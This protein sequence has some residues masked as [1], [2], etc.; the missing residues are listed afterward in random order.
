[1][2]QDLMMLKHRIII[3]LKESHFVTQK[4]RFPYGPD[5]KARDSK[6]SDLKTPPPA[7]SWLPQYSHYVQYTA[8]SAAVSRRVNTADT[9]MN[10][11]H[12]PLVL[13]AYLSESHHNVILSSPWS[14]K[15]PFPNRFSHENSLHCP[16]LPHMQ[17]THR[18]PLDVAVGIQLSGLCVCVCVYICV[19]IY[20]YIPIRKSKVHPVTGHEAPED[21]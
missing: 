1:M 8:T 14:L 21:E 9:A 10:Q 4:L 18:N 16:V 13:T 20:I 15:W 3:V 6:H 2:C 7:F 17:P 19:Y 11:L 12:S 5:V